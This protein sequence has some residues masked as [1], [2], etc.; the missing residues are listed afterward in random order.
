MSVTLA[1]LAGVLAAVGTALVLHRTLTRIVLGL[2]ILGNAVN[3]LVQAA[4]TPPGTAPIIGRSG[5]F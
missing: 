5:R 3:L 1:V 4:G 2:G